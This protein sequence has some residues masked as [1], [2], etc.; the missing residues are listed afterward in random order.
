MKTMHRHIFS[1]L[2]SLSITAFLFLFLLFL[3][4]IFYKPL[5]EPSRRGAVKL[6]SYQKTPMQEQDAP[7]EEKTPEIAELEQVAEVNMLM[8]TPQ[9]NVSMPSMTFDFAPEVAGTVSVAGVPSMAAPSAPKQAAG[10]ALSL[11]DV[12]ELPRPIFAPQPKYPD[13]VK[14]RE[15]VTIRVRVLLGTNGKVLQVSP[16]RVS[17][18]HALFFEEVKTNMLRWEFTPCKKGGKPVQCVA[19][20]PFNFTPR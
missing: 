9:M 1:S 15:K 4:T 13:H 19:E 16:V 3:G 7:T 6:S 8:E 2:G 14:K 11:G 18:E 12:D 17:S 10:G 20:Q 5:D